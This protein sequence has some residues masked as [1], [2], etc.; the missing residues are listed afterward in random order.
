VSLTPVMQ[1]KEL[2]PPL[3]LAQLDQLAPQLIATLQEVV[4]TM[5]LFAKM[6]DALPTPVTQLPTNVKSLFQVAM[7]VMLAQLTVSTHLL[8]VSTLL[9]VL[10]LIIATPHLVPQEH[11]LT[12]QRIVMTEMF[13]LSI[14]ATFA[15]ELVSTLQSPALV[16]PEMLEHAILQPQNAKLERLARTIA[17]AL[18][19]EIQLINH[20]VTLL[21]VVTTP[22][23]LVN[24]SILRT[25]LPIKRSSF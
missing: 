8:A 17:T 14:L 25:F 3:L 22:L 23:L 16:E 19:M 1:L 18:E 15:L 5:Q 6:L 9:N 20:T 4:L 7:I 10:L 2:S 12:L 11:A 24:L 21:L 13:V